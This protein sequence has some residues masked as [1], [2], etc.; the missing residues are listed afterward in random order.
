[1]RLQHIPHFEE[2]RQIPFLAMNNRSHDIQLD[3]AP[4]I[5]FEVHIQIGVEDF[6]KFV[7]QTLRAKKSDI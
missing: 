3:G 4:D 1:M 2:M 5:E 7:D 6:D